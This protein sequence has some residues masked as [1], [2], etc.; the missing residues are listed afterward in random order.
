MLAKFKLVKSTKGTVDMYHWLTG[1][2]L[3]AKLAGVM[4]DG[5]GI[6]L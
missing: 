6:K 3:M 5:I 4:M 2:S 1:A